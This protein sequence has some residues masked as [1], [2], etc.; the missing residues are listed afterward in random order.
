MNAHKLR[1]NFRTYNHTRVHTHTEGPMT[2]HFIKYC[3][4][5][6]LLYKYELSCV[7][8]EALLQELLTEFSGGA[9]EQP[10]QFSL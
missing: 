9:N 8:A 5:R 7:W 4:W 6:L 2:H 10:S 1:R 3:I